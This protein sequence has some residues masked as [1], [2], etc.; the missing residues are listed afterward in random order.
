MRLW[1]Q[2]LRVRC[3]R[4]PWGPPFR[5]VNTPSHSVLRRRTC[6]SVEGHAAGPAQSEGQTVTASVFG[7][8]SRQ[9]L[10]GPVGIKAHPQVKTGISLAFWLLVRKKG[11][12]FLEVERNSLF[13]Q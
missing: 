12:P 10:P 8:G 7:R 6:G 3:V 2:E 13:K 9:R 5:L 1:L 11:V 4:M